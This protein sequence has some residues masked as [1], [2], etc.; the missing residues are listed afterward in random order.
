MK[1]KSK[2]TNHRPPF[3]RAL[4]V[5]EEQA[6]QSLASILFR[7]LNEPI[8][9][10]R[11]GHID[12]GVVLLQAPVGEAAHT[13]TISRSHTGEGGNVVEQYLPGHEALLAGGAGYKSLLV[14]DGKAEAYVHVTRIKVGGWVAEVDVYFCCYCSSACDMY[15]EVGGSSCLCV[16]FFL[17]G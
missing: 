8:T 3:F 5:E 2:P 14:L 15:L 1:K 11:C 12:V 13:V 4:F 9:R 10:L 6:N 17:C 7:G 16:T